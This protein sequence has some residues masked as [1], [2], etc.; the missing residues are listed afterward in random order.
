MSEINQEQINNRN[1]LMKNDVR[2][3]LR[4]YGISDSEYEFFGLRD[5]C[6]CIAR[7][8]LEGFIIFFA[9][10]SETGEWKL[11]DRTGT[12]SFA[13]AV[14]EVAERLYKG[15]SKI[16]LLMELAVMFMSHDFTIKADYI[17]PTKHTTSKIK[18][19]KL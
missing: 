3:I 2:K 8:Q 13:Y 14:K 12:W 11:T 9:E 7:G 4:K 5:G 1:V 15:E 19:K 6:Q 17:K 16:E 10:Y 18:T